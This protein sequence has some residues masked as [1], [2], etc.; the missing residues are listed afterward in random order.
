MCDALEYRAIL[1]DGSTYIGAIDRPKYKDD[2]DKKVIE[3]INSSNST[4]LS[5]DDFRSI[6]YYKV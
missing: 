2:L 6:G 1:R 4:Y 5:I 3:D